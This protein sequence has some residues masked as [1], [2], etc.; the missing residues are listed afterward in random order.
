MVINLLYFNWRTAT[1]ATPSLFDR[2]L[3]VRHQCVAH[4]SVCHARFPDEGDNVWR[5]GLYGCGR[6]SLR[7][8]RN[9]VTIEEHQVGDLAFTLL[10]LFIQNAEGHIDLLSYST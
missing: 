2:S 7:E 5:P 4:C 3:T 6:R 9:E 8:V 1:P 10:R